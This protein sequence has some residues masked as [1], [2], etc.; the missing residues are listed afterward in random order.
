MRADVMVDRITS[1][2][3]RFGLPTPCP[4]CADPK[5]TMYCDGCL[6]LVASVL[7]ISLSR[8]RREYGAKPVDRART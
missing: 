6:S 2:R 8:A 1:A 7:D 3:S 5:A 4:A